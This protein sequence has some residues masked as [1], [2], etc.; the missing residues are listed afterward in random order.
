MQIIDCHAN[1]GWDISNT[2]KNLYPG[3]QSYL[4]LLEKMDKYGI[5]KSIVLP[6]PSPGGQF[7]VNGFWFDLE[8][9]YLI[10]ASR[11]SNKLIPFPGVNPKDSE[12]V[13]NI[14]VLATAYNIKGIKFSHQIPM[15]FSIDKLINHKLMKI[16]EDN[17]LLFMIHIGTGKEPRSHIVHTTLNYAVKVAKKY[18]GIRFILCHMGRLHRSLIEALNLENVYVDTSALSIWPRW[19][20]FI[21]L[22]PMRL[23]K[24]SDPVFV[25][26]KLISKGY[27]NKI[28][29][30]SDEPYASYKSEI[31]VIEKASISEMA[32]R[33]IFYK[34]IKKLLN[35]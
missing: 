35:I 13:K 10:E 7:N 5:E 1:V 32:K 29:F 27:E 31:E 30:G 14:Q 25:I 22:E 11:Q 8:N 17:G 33:K 4:A 15:N 9:Q 19:N 28:I 16:V 12:S 24:N 6:F 23:F 18:P 2:R 21:A 34:N 26:E 20:Q 3:E